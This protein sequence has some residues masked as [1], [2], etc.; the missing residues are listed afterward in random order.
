MNSLYKKNIYEY[1]HVIIKELN[2]KRTD[3]Y[4]SEYNDSRKLILQ[5]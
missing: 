5:N 2:I 3:N 4:F 1:L